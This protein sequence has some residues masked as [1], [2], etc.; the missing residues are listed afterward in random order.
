M[1]SEKGLTNILIF[2][3]I[4]NGKSTLGN[5]LLGYN[6]FNTTNDTNRGTNATIG[7]RGKKGKNNLF[8]IDTPG[9]LNEEEDEKNMIQ[10]I[11]YLKKNKKLNAILVVLNYQ[12]VRFSQSI[13]IMIKLLCAIFP[14]KNIAEH[15]AF[16]FTNAFTK[17]GN[18]SSEQKEVKINK[19]LPEFRK[20]IEEA[21][22]TKVG[23]IISGF[24]DIDLDE[25]INSDGEFDLERIVEWA[26]SLDNLFEESQNQKD[27]FQKLK[28]ENEQFKEE[29]ER[30]KI[31]I[32]LKD[33]KYQKEFDDIKNEISQLKNMKNN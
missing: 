1:H 25:G 5:Q 9:F 22:T 28:D 11:E 12:Q 20:V 16:I 18:L 14:K 23:N 15:I 32:I 30:L 21:T 2:G 4:G 8:V 3:E 33:K 24:V 17:R 7:I 29:I 26:T 10:I 19:I 31:D 6:T 27:D 13:Q